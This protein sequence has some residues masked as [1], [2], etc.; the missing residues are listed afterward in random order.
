MLD[1]DRRR[2]S[3]YRVVTADYAYHGDEFGAD[4]DEDTLAIVRLRGHAGALPLGA[5]S[6]RTVDGRIVGA[7][8]NSADASSR[9]QRTE[10]RVTQHVE[11]PEPDP[12]AADT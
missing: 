4:C 11:Q 6:L 3:I 12:F 5:F 7:W 9:E 1:D 10:V 8:S 2:T